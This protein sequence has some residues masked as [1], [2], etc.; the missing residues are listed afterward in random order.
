MKTKFTLKVAKSGSH[1]TV[2]PEEDEAAI[3][4]FMEDNPD[5]DISEHFDLYNGGTVYHLDKLDNESISIYCPSTEEV[6]EFEGD[7]LDRFRRGKKL[8]LE[9]I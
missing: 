3:I 9:L 8:W 4:K 2:K 7:I 1:L 6:Y 5:T